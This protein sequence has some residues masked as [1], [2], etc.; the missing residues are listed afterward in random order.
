MDLQFLLVI[1][2]YYPVGVRKLAYL[3]ESQDFPQNCDAY[4]N[5][6]CNYNT[7]RDTTI[8]LKNCGSS[9]IRSSWFLDAH[10]LIY[11]P[12]VG[13]NAPSMGST[14]IS[15]HFFCHWWSKIGVQKHWRKSVFFETSKTYSHLDRWVGWWAGMGCVQ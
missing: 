9:T 12:K 1:M 15:F 6:N 2:F 5:W 3:Y 13:T 11:P 14:W 8:T 7:K 4:S 10:N